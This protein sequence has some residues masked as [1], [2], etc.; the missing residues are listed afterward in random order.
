MHME[1]ANK[2]KKIKE[3]N[4]KQL[5]NQLDIKMLG[6]T[7]TKYLKPM[8]DFLGQERARE[9][10]AFGIGIKSHG[11]NMYAMGPSGI[12]KFS[13]IKTVLEEEA[14]KSP[15][16]DDWCYIYNFAEPEKPLPLR[17]PAG[18]GAVFQQDM[19]I[20]LDELSANIV[21]VFESDAY[22]IDLKRIQNEM[23]RK[24]REK[25]KNQNKKISQV[26]TIAQI[27]RE[28]NQKE[29]EMNLKSFSAV[30]KPAVDKLRKKYAKNTEVVNY[31][32]QL[33]NDILEHVTDFIKQDEKSNAFT[34]SWENPVLT[35]YKVNLIVDNRTQ[36][37]APVVFEDSPSYTSLFCRVEHTGEQGTPTT[38][39]TLIKAGAL[40][41]ANGGYLIIESRK[42]KKNRDAW[43]ALKSALYTKQ[44]RIKPIEHDSDTVKP[45][46]LEPIPIPLSVKVILLGERGVYYSLCQYDPDFT[47][48]FKVAIDFDEQIERNSKNIKLYARLIKTIADREKLKHFDASAV[49]AIIDHGSQLADD[50]EK[51]STH[52]RDIEDLL[53][54]SNYWASV[55]NKETIT[56]IEVKKAINAK[57]RRLD[58]SR[59]L[60]YEDILRDF[61]IIKTTGKSIGQVNC[62]SVRRVG[63]FSYG[64]PTRVTA[65]VRAGR[66]ELIDIQR[67][68]KLAGPMHSKAGL[69]ISNYLASKFNEDHLYSLSASISFEQI[70]CWTDGDSASVGELCALLSAISDVPIIQSLA[71]T[72]SID[73]YGQVQAIGGVN[74]KIEGFFDICKVNQFRGKP[75]VIIPKV[76]IKNLMLRD[77]IVKAAKDKKFFIYPIETVDEAISLLTGI[78]VADKNKSG[79]YPAQ[80]L[81]DKIEKKLA[82]FN[83]TRLRKDKN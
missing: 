9:A 45:I 12:G 4:Y 56:H 41:K 68:I 53:L 43:E 82:E 81:Y 61:I 57:I 26:G 33:Q 76:N 48:L 46:S 74:E 69:I 58:R 38:N 6:F 16:P 60:Y 8:D 30:V 64:H 10:L 14:K 2:M 28:K 7:S 1:S 52:I 67:E 75:G 79:K 59:E 51:L 70:Y 73:Q 5:R 35:K 83:R 34:F 15:I 40:H 42:L 66:G 78:E 17:F 44:I 20:L 27:C 25:N 37:G 29:K 13:L 77:D 65:R 47:E 18:Q 71:I 36:Q 50:R 72:G 49:G 31:L 63:N 80:S 11:Y 19:K 54:E 32:E 24:Q 21:A 22:H 3:L 55:A 39:F 23:K 62:L